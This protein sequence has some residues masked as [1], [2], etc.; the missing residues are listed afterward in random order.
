MSSAHC[1]LP[2]RLHSRSAAALCPLHCTAASYDDS[3]PYWYIS[4]SLSENP[5]PAKL[6]LI[7]AATA[8][9]VD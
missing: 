6:L 2:T 5:S 3:V 8:Q 7:D 4:H 1:A 9:T